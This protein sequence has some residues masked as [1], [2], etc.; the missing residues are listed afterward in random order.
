MIGVSSEFP[1]LEEAGGLAESVADVDR[2]G[3]FLLKEIAGVRKNRGDTGSNCVSF[4]ECVMTDSDSRDISDGVFRPGRQDPW[5]DPELADTGSIGRL[6]R[7]DE[8]CSDQDRDQDQ[9]MCRRPTHAHLPVSG[10]RWNRSK[11]GKNSSGA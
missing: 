2:G 10:A 1:D 7:G 3:Q 6:F 4:D 5:L 9:T 8:R 11:K